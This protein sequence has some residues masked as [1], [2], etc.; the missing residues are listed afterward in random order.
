MKKLEI[1]LS[2]L[3]LERYDRQMLI[4]GWKEEGQKKLKSAKV[5]VMGAGGLGCPASLYLAAAGV[6]KL[7]IIDKYVQTFNHF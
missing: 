5:V 1:T 4:S 3:E 2:N 6:G 7:I